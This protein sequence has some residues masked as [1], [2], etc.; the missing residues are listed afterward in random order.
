MK[1]VDHEQLWALAAGEALEGAEAHVGSCAQ[2]RATLA[3]IQL[4][5]RALAALPPV[6]ELPLAVANRVGEALSDEVDRQAAR[7][8]TAWWRRLFEP[9]LVLG[10][11]TAAA[12]VFVLAWSLGAFAPAAPQPAPLV[13]R[14]APAPTPTPV[15][16]PTPPA[17]PPQKLSAT[18]ASTVKTS[19]GIKRRQ[20]AKRA[21]Q[22]EEG[23]VVATEAGG[24]V[25]LQLPDGSQAGLTGASEVTLAT[26]EASTLALTVTQGS[27]AMVV[28]H[29]ADRLLTVQAGEV[30]VKDLGTRFLVSKS[31][32]RVLVAVEEGSVEV[33]TPAGSQTLTAGHAVSWHDGQL[34][35]LPWETTKPAAP[36][37][38]KPSVAPKPSPTPAVEEHVDAGVEPSVAPTATAA[39][40][41][42]TTGAPEAPEGSDESEWATLPEGDQPPPPPPPPQA[43]NT[44]TPPPP[45][46]RESGFS[47]RN[48]EQRLQEFARQVQ[49]P[50]LNSAREGQVK[51]IT[52]LADGGDCPAAL[53]AA[54]RWLEAPVS[55]SA[56]EARWR[57]SVLM[58]KMRCL[59]RLGRADEA[60]AT[61]A[62]LEVL[63]P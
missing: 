58:Q 63:G 37:R 26:L 42:S 32:A 13:H 5:Q 20:L 15:S 28:P 60:N 62:E 29:R 3:D 45:R 44:A 36:L 23:S 11:A 1:H 14:E 54:E 35:T 34:D 39:A 27:L 18:V 8:F 51:L 57:R 6:P 4:A 7:R 21:Q 47:L 50:F 33:T 9:R 2:C 10:F 53:S 48:L 38:P 16:T 52:K 46:R 43:V 17:P 59:N 49:S 61:K 19:V 56:H 12:A 40:E 25:W 55:A 30:Q 31:S 24:S 41:P 22:L